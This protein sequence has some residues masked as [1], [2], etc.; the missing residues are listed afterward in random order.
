MA[1]FKKIFEDLASGRPMKKPVSSNLLK[2]RAKENEKALKSGFMKMPDYVKKKFNEEE[3]KDY[4]PDKEHTMN[5]TSHVKKEGDKFCVYNM[6]GKKVAS[7][8][9][10]DKADAYA[11]KNH[12][13]LMKEAK[14]MCS[15]DCDCGK[16][17]CE[18]CGKPKMPKDVKEAYGIKTGSKQEADK[19][20]D[21]A[22]AALGLKKKSDT[23]LVKV[24]GGFE[25]KRTYTKESTR[26][27]YNPVVSDKRTKAK[28]KKA[29]LPPE[30]PKVMEAKK[31]IVDLDKAGIKDRLK[32][33]KIKYNKPI[34]VKVSDIGP[35]GKE[36]V[37]KNT[38]NE[39]IID[40]DPKSNSFNRTKA[41]KTK[42]KLG[43]K[44]GKP[45][46]G[47]TTTPQ[48]FPG[49]REQQMQIAT[50]LDFN[51][52]LTNLVSRGLDKVRSSIKDA[53]NRTGYK[54]DPAKRKIANPVSGENIRKR[55]ESQKKR[56]RTEAH[57]NED[58]R[59]DPTPGGM[60]WGTDKGDNY[61]RSL[62]P[63]QS[64]KNRKAPLKP[65]P[66]KARKPEDEKAAIKEVA[67]PSAKAER[68]VKHIKKAYGKD[69]KLTDREKSIAYAT[70]WKHHN[71]ESVEEEISPAEKSKHDYPINNEKET[72]DKGDKGHF[73]TG[74]DGDWYIEQAD[75]DFLDKEAENY[76]FD[77]A[78]DDG[79]YDEEELT[80]D[81]F[82]NTPGFDNEIEITEALSVQGR[83]K[84][85]FNARR[86]KQKLRVARGIALRRGSTPDRLKRRATRGARLMVYKRL[87]RGRDRSSL[88]PAE[89]ARLERMIKRFAPLVSR[90]SVKLLPQMRRN[91]IKRLTGRGKK[92]PTSSKK[93]RA[94]K[95]VRSA[96]SR[97]AKKFKVKAGGYKA[98]KAKKP[99][100]RIKSGGPTLKKASKAYKAFSYSVG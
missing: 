60:E 4:N 96:S 58:A 83:L 87:L 23:G 35:G 71:K 41:K 73:L 16:A 90:I 20:N 34:G 81:D 86:N 80:M 67:P 59:Y 25:R 95:P 8:D 17:I 54:V 85:R 42:V 19:L 39:G 62:T 92:R 61:Y 13:E 21:K 57:I 65:L 26:D 44:S 5:P 55:L 68:M 3:K 97:K 32:T 27:N 56:L 43:T 24:K 10:K 93:Y 33:V 99:K 78:V 15:C 49:L 46:Y 40:R 66:I 75:I 64:P 48:G 79:L 31:P 53:E 50:N 76:T 7:F 74:K 72:F 36:Y 28:L 70:A 63:G 45:V 12:D 98:P 52:G 82:D 9:T 22:H 30:S 91:E 18:S 88:P 94:A 38:M 89:K 100:S 2:Q 47:T 77:Q 69:G 37:R 84:R 14:E 6:K 11:K 51:E 29:G 1:D